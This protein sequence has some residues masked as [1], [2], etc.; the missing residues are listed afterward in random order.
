MSRLNIRFELTFVYTI[1]MGVT[2]VLVGFSIER[3][4]YNRISASINGYL[5]RN[6]GSVISTVDELILAGVSLSQLPLDESFSVLNPPPWPPR[7]VQLLD[8]AGAVIYRSQNLG[9]SALPVDTTVIAA[10]GHDMV[11]SP[12]MKLYMYSTRKSGNGPLA[13]ETVEIIPSRAQ[14]QVP[15]GMALGRTESLRMITFPLRYVDGR[16]V[17]WGQVAVSLHEVDRAKSKTR[18][19][20]AFILPSAFA[21]SVLLGW[22]LARRLLRPIDVITMT[23]RRVTAENLSERLERRRA[24]DEL[25]RLTDTLNDLLERLERNFSQMKRFSSDVSHELRTPL[26]IIQGEAEVALRPDVSPEEMRRS[27]EVVLDESQRMSKLVKNLLVLSRL[28]TGQEQVVMTCVDLREVMDELIEQA[29]A[30]AEVKGI[31]VHV[32]HSERAE[33]MGDAVMLRQ[34]M[35]NL[36]HNAVKYTGE[37]GRVSLSLERFNGQVRFKVTDT[38]I[39]ID[40]EDAEHIFDRFYRGDQV[41]KHSDGG[42]GLGLSLVKQ[43]VEIHKGTVHMKS[44]PGK[45]SSFVVDLPLRCD[46]DREEVGA[47]GATER[48]HT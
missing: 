47:A 44:I 43:I 20:L 27:L 39:G 4:A 33:V 2:L 5:R 31:A 9:N 21:L 38:G 45:G 30:L 25:G 1:V 24:D 16:P 26:T 18:L 36:I 37:G 14:P 6:A 46:D 19:A 23:A 28:E 13:I 3:L 10:D 48:N 34:M 40:A 8:T 22:W 17:G 42:T 41:R 11:I 15:A 7:Y 35:F 12:D 32:E 29:E